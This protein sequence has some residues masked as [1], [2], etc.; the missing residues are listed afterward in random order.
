MRGDRQAEPE[1]F[2]RAALR[3]LA[4]STAEKART[5]ADVRDAAAAMEEM[6]S[7]PSD[8]VSVV[9]RLCQ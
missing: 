7:N 3:W 1:R 6:R 9:R 2:E 5:L 8:A 4:R